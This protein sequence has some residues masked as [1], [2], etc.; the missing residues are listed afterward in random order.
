MAEDTQGRYA[1]VRE[2]RARGQ[3]NTLATRAVVDELALDLAQQ[4]RRQISHSLNLRLTWDQWT[5]LTAIIQTRIATA[6]LHTAFDPPPFPGKP[7]DG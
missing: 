6:I 2:L 3:D 7:R 5:Q 4:T 1:A